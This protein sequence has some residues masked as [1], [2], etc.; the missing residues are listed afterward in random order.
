MFALRQVFGFFFQATGEMTL[1][2]IH[3]SGD[4]VVT[5]PHALDLLAQPLFEVNDPFVEVHDAAAGA[6]DLGDLSHGQKPLVG[7]DAHAGTLRRWAERPDSIASAA[8]VPL[9]NLHL[10]PEMTGKPSRKGRTLPV[11]CYLSLSL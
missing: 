2:D 3:V 1:Q 11:P 5:A 9:I 4:A 6:I 8:T 7:R 10:P